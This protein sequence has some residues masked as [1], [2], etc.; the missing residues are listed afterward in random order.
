MT[1]STHLALP[2][3]HGQDSP[4]FTLVTARV[5]REL[6][7]AARVL[8]RVTERLVHESYSTDNIYVICL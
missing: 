7:T 1:R 6:V 2:V 5:V 8:L 4:V 3:E